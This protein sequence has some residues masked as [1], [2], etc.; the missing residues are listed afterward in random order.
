MDAAS[1]LEDMDRGASL[2][3]HHGASWS[4]G[5][6]DFCTY[7]Q[8]KDSSL[9]TASIPDVPFEDREQRDEF[10]RGLRLDAMPPDHLYLDPQL[11]AQARTG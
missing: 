5:L 9:G 3:A 7:K 4:A 6:L 8:A 11:K 10:D 2:R 1:S